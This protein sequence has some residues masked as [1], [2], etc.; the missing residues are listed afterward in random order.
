MVYGLIGGLASLVI[1]QFKKR[2]DRRE[3]IRSIM[4]QLVDIHSY[5]KKA[6]LTMKTN[7]HNKEIY[8]SQIQ[9]LVEALLELEQLRK[10][11]EYIY[12]GRLF[13]KKDD[14]VKSLDKMEK[15]LSDIN[16]EYENKYAPGKSSAKL[17]DLKKLNDFIGPYRNGNYN[18]IYNRNYF[19]VVQYLRKDIERL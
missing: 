6:R 5:L 1:E 12:D 11:I 17:Q 18:N 16:A 4:H 8:E 14:L 10:A 15:Y 2:E 7:V 9:I 13:S 3:L 19:H